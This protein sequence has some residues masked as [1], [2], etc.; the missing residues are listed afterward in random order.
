M[1]ASSESRAGS[2][3]VTTGGGQT[4]LLGGVMYASGGASTQPDPAFVLEDGTLSVSIGEVSY[5]KGVSYPVLVRRTRNGQSDD[6]L[7]PAQAPGGVNASLI[8]LF[9]TE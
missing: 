1:L 8:P 5:R 4:E 2:A 9:V 7:L 3:V 6:V